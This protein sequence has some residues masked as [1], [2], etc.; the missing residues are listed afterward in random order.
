MPDVILLQEVDSH[1]PLPI[2][3]YTAHRTEN[4]RGE[5]TAV[6]LFD[7]SF[8][9][10]GDMANPVV[11]LGACREHGWK[12]STVVH[13]RRRAVEDGT[14]YAF[15]SVH[16]RH[17]N[18]FVQNALLESTLSATS[19]D[20]V[21]VLAGDFN[22]ERALISE[23]ATPFEKRN[24]V[25][26]PIPTGPTTLGCCSREEPGFRIATKGEERLIDHV[27]VD[28]RDVDGSG[29]SRLVVK[30]GEWEVGTLPDLGK[31]PRGP[32]G[33]RGGD[34]SDHAWIRVDMSVVER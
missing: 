30:E 33:D 22:L 2:P 12:S 32:W 11:R 16:L 4:G 19:P 17:N 13:A 20:S 21:R 5:G 9:L 24:M 26:V 27:W 31:E 23:V 7:Q 28:D 14:T 29:R 15:C 25:R 34:G 8:V 10:D 18:A 6:L 1:F 3:G